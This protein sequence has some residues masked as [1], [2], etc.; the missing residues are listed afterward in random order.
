MCVVSLCLTVRDCRLSNLELLRE[1]STDLWECGPG[2]LLVG[3]CES[4]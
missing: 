3:L 4:K 2:T 1:H